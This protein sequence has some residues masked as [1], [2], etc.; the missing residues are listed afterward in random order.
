MNT[1]LLS[2]LYPPESMEEVAR[3]SKDGLQSQINSYQWAVVKG[4]R[5]NLQ[6]GEELT[7]MNALPV[8]AFPAH[9]CKP[10]LPQRK[11]DNYF[12]LGSWNLPWLK[13]WAR[14]RKTVNFLREW[15][16]K[17]PENNQVLVYS[18]YL[19]YMR[20]VAKVKKFFPNLKATVII[21]DLPN[22]MGISS[23]RRM[24][25]KRLEYA[26]GKRKIKICTHFD[27][28]VLLTKHMA[29]V[30]PIDQKPRLVIEGLI[31]PRAGVNQE[32]KN[33]SL[34][35]KSAHPTALYTGT[36]NRELGIGELIEAFRNLP[37]CRLWLC[38]KGDMEEAVKK[39]AA[40]HSNITYFGFVSQD[41]AVALQQQAD[42]LINPRSGS[43]LFTRY[44]FPSKTLEYMRSGK[45]T[46]CYPLE[47]IPEDYAPYLTYI[48]RDGGIREA[49]Q[50]LL[51]MPAADRMQLGLSAQAF[52]EEQK[53][54]T[55]QC[56]KLVCFLRRLL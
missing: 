53:N 49:V 3:A 9:Y 18:L 54:P 47:G 19:P 27:G 24:L 51:A 2:L 17:N 42:V 37:D 40:A 29:E 8:G 22:E 28:F 32:T 16:G 14:R 46:I 31:L 4:I 11:G 43:H 35:E 10:T 12:E 5:E 30:L 7:L 13:Q 56:K 52:V 6:A 21:T 39:A 44:S 55:V 50:S 41:E 25:L 1:L 26:M 45:P 15:A 20:A 48:Q 34:Q 23:G 36:L 38:G 33:P